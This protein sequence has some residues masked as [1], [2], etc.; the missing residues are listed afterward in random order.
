MDVAIAG[1]QL[2]ADE[3]DRFVADHYSRLVGL[4]VLRTRD[5]HVAEELAHESLLKLVKHWDRVRLM[6]NRWAWLAT[7]AINQSRSR[8]RRLTMVE[9]VEGRLAAGDRSAEGAPGGEALTELLAVIGRLPERQRSALLLRHYARLSVRE[10]AEAMG[11]AEGTVKSLTNRAV[12]RLRSELG[13]ELD[14]SEL[15]E[16]DR[17]ATEVNDAIDR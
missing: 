9:R 13:D 17:P 1:E 14:G 16:A 12:E 8:W 6:E 4:L 5:R 3:L 7:V 2:V 10:T 15:D 11:C